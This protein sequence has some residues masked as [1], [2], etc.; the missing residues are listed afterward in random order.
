MTSPG[1]DWVKNQA[2]ILVPPGTDLPDSVVRAEFTVKVVGFA[3]P[4]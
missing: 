3:V 2:G 4:K 1:T